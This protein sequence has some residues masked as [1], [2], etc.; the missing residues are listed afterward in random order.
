MPVLRLEGGM[1]CFRGHAVP[2]V[3]F[4]SKD[5]DKAKSNEFFYTLEK[6]ACEPT[7]VRYYSNGLFL[8]V[9]NKGVLFSW[10]NKPALLKTALAEPSWAEY[11]EK[12]DLLVIC[13][14]RGNLQI[15]L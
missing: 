9:T 11:L 14:N 1:V 15:E 12:E 2:L 10:R 8:V 5:K 4:F 6:N 13:D 7:T 3:Y